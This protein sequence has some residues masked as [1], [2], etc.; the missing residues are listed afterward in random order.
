MSKTHGMCYT[1]I[2]R[3]W[4]EMINRCRNPNSK[5]YA[6]YGGRGISVCASW[7]KFENFY[8]DMGDR[9][10]GLTLDRKKNN[11]GYSKANCQWVTRSEQQQNSRQTIWITFMGRKQTIKQWS[12]ETGI[13]ITALKQRRL[14]GWSVKRMLTQ[15]GLR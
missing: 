14:A 12:I 2:Y 10:K 1:P 5:D 15:P 3:L 11:K 6:R 8:K 4:K 7:L 9:P 13:R